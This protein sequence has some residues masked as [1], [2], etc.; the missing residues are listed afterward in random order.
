MMH[1]RLRKS[2]KWVY[3]FLAVVF[4]VSFVI[5]GR[6]HRRPVGRRP[7]PGQQQDDQNN[8]VDTA[9]TPSRT[10]RPRTTR[11]NDPQA[12]LALAEAQRSEG[13]PVKA[14]A[15]ADKA[16][17]LAKDDPDVNEGGGRD[18]RRARGREP[19]K[20][21]QIFPR[22]QEL[23]QRRACPP[24]SYPGAANAQDPLSLATQNAAQQQL[25]A[26]LDQAQPFQDSAS[27]AFKKAADRS[28]S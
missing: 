11:P 26:L 21:N 1:E 5:A 22:Y 7:D 17:S 15:S 9:P 8:S 14:S 20:A 18:L 19:E 27:A 10:R 13:D 4:A 16:I 28:W 12:W 6:R 23:A 3:L 2:A 25:N 24:T